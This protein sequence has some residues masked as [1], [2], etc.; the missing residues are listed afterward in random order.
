MVL[1]VNAETAM[2]S[3]LHN[4]LPNVQEGPAAI[5]RGGVEEVQRSEISVTRSA[6]LC[7]SFWRND[8]K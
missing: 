1:G 3:F 5:L 7:N 2:S 4:G 6:T 8:W